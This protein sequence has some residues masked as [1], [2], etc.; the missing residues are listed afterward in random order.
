MESGASRILAGF[1]GMA[2]T[3]SRIRVILILLLG[4]SLACFPA[5]PLP[6]LGSSLPSLRHSLDHLSQKP[7]RLRMFYSGP[8]TAAVDRRTERR[9][10]RRPA[11]G[12]RP[13]QALAAR[14]RL[15]GPR[16]EPIAIALPV[17]PLRC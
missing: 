2:R 7:Q 4:T 12:N 11:R 5:R 1:Q 13:E 3:R 14:A 9:R 8:S 6:L 16:P 17:H 10:E 15:A